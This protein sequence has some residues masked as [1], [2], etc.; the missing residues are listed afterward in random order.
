MDHL[1]CDSLCGGGV[2]RHSHTPCQLAGSGAVSSVA[3]N[4]VLMVGS[5][6]GSAGRGRARQEAAWLSGCKQG[7]K[8]IGRAW[9]GCR[10]KALLCPS[11]RDGEGGRAGDEKFPQP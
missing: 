10:R 4:D 7:E 3:P 2:Q 9:H 5:A 6:R 11:A 8:S 1:Q